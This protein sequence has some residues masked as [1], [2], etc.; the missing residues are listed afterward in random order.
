MRRF[1]RRIAVILAIALLAL[2]CA[3]CVETAESRQAKQGKEQMEAWLKTRGAKNASVDTAY[4]ER[5]K[6]APDRVEMTQFV[7]GD[8]R[9]DGQKYE[10]W[11]NVETGEIFTS[12]RI[13]QFKAA[14]Y[15]LML[16]ALG[17]DGAHCVGLCNVDFA[18]A[19]RDTVIPAEIDDPEGYARAHL[20]TDAFSA[21][22]WLVCSA[23]EAPSGRWTA[24]DTADWN[25]DVARVCVVPAGEALP[26][27]GNGVNLGYYYFRDFEGDKYIM[28]SQ[29]VE[30][31]PGK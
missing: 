3:G 26:E 17:V 2:G 15:D 18:R 24:E 1:T 4:T 31:T 30:Y 9:I 14:C 16:E 12:E 28:T 25:Q 22:L 8:Y 10:Y 11:V 13:A 21:F 19:P 29:A 20:H 5:E 6:P 7:H 27:F 23:S